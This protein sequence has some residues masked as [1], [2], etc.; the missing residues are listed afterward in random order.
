MTSV[1]GSPVHVE[2]RRSGGFAGISLTAATSTDKL[3]G[4]HAAQVR[5]LLAKPEAEPRQAAPGGADR[6]QYNLRLD[7]G[8]HQR[9]YSWDDS[10]VPDEVRP[11][12]GELTRMARPG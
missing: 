4:E 7:D 8:Q 3:T 5:D 2:F 10:Q 1:P 9:A 6:F 12:L 11:L